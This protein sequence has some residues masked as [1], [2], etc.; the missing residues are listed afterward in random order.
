MS[1]FESATLISVTRISLARDWSDAVSSGCPSS[2]RS[3]T[4]MHWR[5]SRSLT[6]SIISDWTFMNVR[7]I[8]S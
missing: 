7:S 5:T 3:R 8:S 2:S 1:P 4:A 6:Q